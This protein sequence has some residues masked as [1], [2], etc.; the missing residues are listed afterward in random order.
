ML[1]S[2]FFFTF[3]RGVQKA[4]SQILDRAEILTLRVIPTNFKSSKNSGFLKKFR[5]PKISGSPSSLGTRKCQVLF[6]RI[7]LEYSKI[8]RTSPV[9][10]SRNQPST[11]NF[12]VV[13]SSRNLELDRKSRARFEPS[14]RD[15]RI[16]LPFTNIL[17]STLKSSYHFASH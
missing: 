12:L 13:S 3:S 11:L 16:P 8:S 6:R 14:L 5:Y 17:L 1:L 9:L 4:R 2:Y 10:G 7:H 15:F